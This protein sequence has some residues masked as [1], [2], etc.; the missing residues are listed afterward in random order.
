[1]HQHQPTLS[2]SLAEWQT[3]LDAMSN[4]LEPFQS[5]SSAAPAV[6]ATTSQLS[7]FS[8]TALECMVHFQVCSRKG[9]SLLLPDEPPAAVPWGHPAAFNMNRQM[10]ALQA[11]LTPSSFD[12]PAISASNVPP[13]TQSSNVK[14][15]GYGSR[16]PS[17]L[18]PSTPI[19]VV[20][21]SID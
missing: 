6:T 15:R 9:V 1:M 14:K 20:I 11:L 18:I 5:S 8:R 21:P 2:T 19:H 10:E 13:S 7:S 4:A 3:I 16:F 12:A 17:C